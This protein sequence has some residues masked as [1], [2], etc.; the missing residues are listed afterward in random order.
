M[1]SDF[2]VR[3]RAWCEVVVRIGVNLQPG[4]PLLITDP[5]DLLGVHPDAEVFAAAIRSVA[6][7]RTQILQAHPARLRA[8]A[9]G[10]DQKGYVTLVAT[11][12]AWLRHHLK[13]G[14]A[15]LFLTGGAPQLFQG[16]PA[17]RL[18]RFHAVKWRLLGPIIQRLVRG[19][20]QW[21]LL[22]APSHDWS[23]AAGLSLPG[24]YE[25]LSAAFRLDQSD[26]CA[27]WRTQLS[28]LAAR[29]DE[30]NAARYRRIRYLG[31]GTDL[32]LELPRSH[33]WCT[34]QLTTKAGVPFV[35]NLPTEEIFTAPHKSSARGTVR[36]ARPIVHGGKVIDGIQLEFRDG[37]VVGASARRGDDDLRQ[38]FATDDGARGVGEVAVVPHPPAWSAKARLFHH[39]LLDENAAPHIALGDAYRFCSRALVPL[40]LNRSQIHVDLP[41]DAEVE[42]S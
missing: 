36:V 9:E 27:S 21:T 29:R 8:L 17:A 18:A 10:D 19:A 25:I 38:L 41:L 3:L 30:L 11:H 28:T 40:A 12:A 39:T 13:R 6:G 22:P 33:V 23:S 24:L 37:Q 31:P 2:D 5:Y 42:L 16:L 7:P 34:A 14:G 4:Q 1:P 32:T 26:P 20:S 15:F 35:A